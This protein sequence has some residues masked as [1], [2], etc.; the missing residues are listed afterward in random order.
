VEVEIKCFQQSAEEENGDGS[1]ARELSDGEERW[2]AM[3]NDISSCSAQLAW[4]SFNNVTS[5]IVSH[6]YV[7]DQV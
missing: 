7:L 2:E 6:S 3:E 1:G 5:D 4:F